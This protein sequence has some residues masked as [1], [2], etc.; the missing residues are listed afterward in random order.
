[1]LRLLRYLFLAVVAVVLIVLALANR[2]SV[3]LHLLPVSMGDFLGFSWTVQLPLFLVI[4]G[5]ILLGLLLGFVW[6]WFRAHRTRAEGKIAKKQAKRLER[7]VGKLSQN[8][9]RPKDEV[10]VLLDKPSV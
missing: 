6:E 4:F 7:E 3:E 2:A 8:D 9:G 5:G 1:M 10:L